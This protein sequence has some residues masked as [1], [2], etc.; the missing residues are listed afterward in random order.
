MGRGFTSPKVGPFL[1]PGSS[2]LRRLAW[3]LTRGVLAA[4]AA[5]SLSSGMARG[6]PPD[7]PAEA[8]KPSTTPARERPVYIFLNSPVDL[9]SL[10]RMLDRPDFVLQKGADPEKAVEGAKPV[11]AGAEPWPVV[12]RSVVIRG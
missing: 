7:T 4:M 9:E 8:A 10:W 6:A 12:V 11:P 2:D 5:A 1:S 3:L